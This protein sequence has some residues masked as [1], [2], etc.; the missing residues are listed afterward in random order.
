M[1]VEYEI[2]TTAPYGQGLFTKTA[3]KKG[4]R[5][6][7]YILHTNVFEFNAM[8]TQAH[9]NSLADLGEQQRFLDL[10]F[11][12][13]E[14]LCLITDDG[15]FMNHA[16]MGTLNCNCQT[17]LITGHCYALRDILAGEQLFEDYGRFS[18]PAF[19]YPLLKKYACEPTYYVLPQEAEAI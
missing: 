15:Q 18:H 1:N 6:W 16:D 12:K 14:V 9:L 5:I 2:R 10:T 4:T 19:L 13:Q 3:V 11:G 7:S 8:Q 17:E